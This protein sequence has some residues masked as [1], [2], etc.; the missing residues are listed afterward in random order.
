M[1]TKFT[2]TN[3]KS[4]REPMTFDLGHPG[5]YE[6]NT[7]AVKDGVITKGMVYGFNGC[8]KSNLGLAMFDITAHLTNNPFPP[9]FHFYPPYLN[10]DFKESES[11]D[12]VYQFR[13]GESEVVYHY[14]KRDVSTLL[15]ESLTID[16]VEVV[17]YDFT[18]H[19]GFVAL[20]G[21][22][23]LNLNANQSNMSRVKFVHSNALLPSNDQNDVFYQFMN[24]VSRMSLMRLLDKPG[25]QGP[26]GGNNEDV[27][28]FIIDMDKV[29]DFE[30][31]LQNSNVNLHLGVL[32]S[33]FENSKMLIA[34]FK[35][36][37]ARFWDIASTGTSSLAVLYCWALTMKQ[38]SFV[39]LD[40]FDAF[41]HFELAERIVKLVMK[42]FPD[43]QVI[44]TTQNTDLLSNDI[45]RPDCYFWLDNS[46][47]TPLCDLT[48]TEIRKA[49]NLQKMFKAGDF[50]EGGD[51]E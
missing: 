1:L 24:F 26:A 7:Q 25:Y 20:K 48:D 21:A 36:G 3:F 8:G 38:N 5:G 37:F 51:Y 19:N 35:N 47:I 49:H 29:G 22:E 40:E 50:Q 15:M 33:A 10:L 9:F 16:K 41:Y 44:F 42:S 12:F 32:E 6:F 17:H 23:T 30:Q 34:K 45:L 13:F 2:V 39:F 27:T 4:F 11:A 46:T 31:F 18:T 28:Q 43:T 14:Q